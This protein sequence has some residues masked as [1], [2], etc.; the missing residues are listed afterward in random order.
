MK[1]IL[2]FSFLSSVNRMGNSGLLRPYKPA[3]NIYDGSIYLLI[4]GNSYS[5][6]GFI[7]GLFR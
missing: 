1:Y 5:A 6:T 3:K 7:S 4:N 2:L